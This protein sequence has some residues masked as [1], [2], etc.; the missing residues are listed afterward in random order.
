MSLTSLRAGRLTGTFAWK[1]FPGDCDHGSQEFQSDIIHHRI[2]TKNQA[3]LAAGEIKDANK[4]GVLTT[5]G[6]RGNFFLLFG[7]SNYDLYKTIEKVLRMCFANSCCALVVH[8][9]G[10]QWPD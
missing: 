8:F 4:A 10:E 9:A 5:A 3:V 2:E 7:N 1:T 6:I